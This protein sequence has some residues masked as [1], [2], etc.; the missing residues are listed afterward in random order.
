MRRKA[1]GPKPRLIKRLYSRYSLQTFRGGFKALI[2]Y[3]SSVS[4][5]R[6]IL[7]FIMLG[8]QSPQ[9]QT[10]Q[11][12]C[13]SR[14]TRR[15]KRPKA[16]VSYI[17]TRAR[18]KQ[19]SPASARNTVAPSNSN[20]VES[21]SVINT[22]TG[23]STL[24]SIST[25]AVAEGETRSVS[26]SVKD[27]EILIQARAQGLN[28][29]QISPKHFPNKSANACRKRHERLMERQNAEQWDGVKLDILAQAY[30]EARREMWSILAA[31]VGEKWTLIEQK[32]WE[33][34]K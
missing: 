20:L 19:K 28:W 14:S 10:S 3:T 11:T 7:I 8:F 26:W 29:N 21:R 5:F 16:P 31:R 17:A 25:D 27:D 1:I 24:G 6:R 15:S 9:I 22:D 18:L 4:I 2:S 30:L 13:A 12:N 32:V 33:A 34:N 23:R